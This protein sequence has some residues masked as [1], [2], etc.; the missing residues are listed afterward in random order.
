[1][2]RTGFFLR[3]CGVACIALLMSA[4]SHNAYD[5]G[6]SRYSYLRTD[7]AEAYTDGNGAL[8]SAI[9]D[10]GDSLVFTSTLQ[11]AWAAKPDSVYRTLLY[12]NLQP[13]DGVTPAST[14]SGVSSASGSSSASSPAASSTE[15]LRVE[16]VNAAL[17]YV[18]TPHMGD[19]SLSLLRDPVVFQSAWQSSNKR[20]INLGLALMTGEPESDGARQTIGM[21]CDTITTDGNGNRM[22]Y[23]RFCHDQGGVPEY[24]KSSVY[25][26]IPVS[27]LRAGDAVTV[28][29]PTYDG[30]VVRVFR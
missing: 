22:F 27:G 19:D 24:Y 25:V 21:I 13:A 23:L 15:P 4:C 11:R 8:W 26:S 14:A 17:V 20:Y 29:I 28:T 3:L 5:T 18:L 2:G 10:D 30:P 7:F 6:D 1:M 16:P 9:T 12:Y